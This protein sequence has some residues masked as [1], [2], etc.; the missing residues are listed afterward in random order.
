MLVLSESDVRKCLDMNTCLAVNRQALIAVASG[1][2]VV[3]SRLALQYHPPREH[4]D[5]ISPAAEDWSLFKP[6]SLH[7]SSTTTTLQMGMKVVSVRAENPVKGFPLVPAT[8]LH[9]DPDT[10]IVDA[11][12]A[13]TYLTGAR[14]A[15]GSAVA[16][17]HYWKQTQ[18]SSAT[19]VP[20]PHVV[21]FGAGLQAE[22]HVHAIG[23]A[24]GST[25][26]ILPSVTL[27]NRS[28][29]RAEQ[30]KNTLIRDG[31]VG[32]C[33]VVLLHDKDAVAAAL[34]T[35]CVIV[36]C[37]NAVAPLWDD[38]AASERIP[39]SC[40]I[41]GIG[42]YTASMREV[43]VATVNRC[44][45]VWIDT[46]EA[47]TVG[48]LKHLKDEKHNAPPVQLLGQVL[49]NGDSEYRQNGLVFYKAVGTAIQDVLTADAVVKR[50][51]EL[52]IGTEVDMS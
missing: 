2:A 14:T 10:G 30:L 49:Q 15:A 48:D 5:N 35:A 21:I 39:D 34:Q 46:P 9:M 45:C 24:F 26:T 23:A 47:A 36:T 7:A 17:Q 16:I 50:A 12:L 1:D 4:N 13:A 44:R 20:P 29:P 43:P 42:S 28:A 31:W 6:A 32:E 33:R 37:T 52:N 19:V 27:V 41:V 8:V 11:V 40:I 25:G 51:R 38:A 18:Q 3:P 22:Q